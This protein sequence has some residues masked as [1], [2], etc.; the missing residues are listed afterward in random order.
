MST[1]ASNPSTPGHRSPAA[2]L[3]RIVLVTRQTRLEEM[4]ARFGTLG[5]AKFKVKRARQIEGAHL[6]FSALEAEHDTY[7]RSLDVL[8]R[9]LEL[10]LKLQV[11]DR[12][13]APSY[14]FTPHDI[15]VT[16]GQDGLVA[17]T[18]KYATGQPIVAVN[19]DP[20]RFDG[21]LLPFLPRQVAP[22][23]RRVIAGRAQL[24]PVTLAEARLG[25][26]QRLLAFNDL[27]I[28]TRS[29]VSARYLISVGGKQEPQSSSGVIVST[30]AGSTGWLSSMFNMAAG[31]S[32]FAGQEPVAA[33]PFA[34]EDPRLFFVVR[35]PFASRTSGAIIVA[36]EIAPED[37]LVLESHMPSGGVIF[38]DG[39]ENDALVFD[40]PVVAHISAAE[41]QALLV[42]P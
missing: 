42:M 22:A 33:K 24:R 34:W 26:G 41:Q 30:G 12:S 20:D 18:A 3:E 38:S 19:P 8:M 17:N 11:I 39:M 35:E 10:G 15:V 31:I 6:D 40:S 1:L 29:H 28:G 16:L 5:Q 27:F 2:D 21:V 25:D 4:R 7:H 14:L 9:Q 37:A 23:L 36:G 13:F 32:R